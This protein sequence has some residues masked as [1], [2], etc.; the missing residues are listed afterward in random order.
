MEES[1]VEGNTWATMENKGGAFKRLLD[2]LGD[3]ELD[4]DSI[5]EYTVHLF[6]K[7][8]QP[9]SVATDIRK[10]RA[11]INWTS[12][13]ERGITPLHW[14]KLI[15]VPKV[16]NKEIDVPSAEIAEKIIYEGANLDKYNIH[17]AI[18]NEARDCMLLMLR[19]GLRV[20]EALNLK[21]EDL[22]LE[23]EGHEWFRVASKGKHGEKD[24]LPLMASAVEIL[25]RPRVIRVGCYKGQY[26][27][28]SEESLNSML[29]RGCE[30]LGVAK[31]TTHKLR[32]IFGTEMA[33]A[34]IPSYHLQRL[35]RHSELETT[36]RYYIHLQLEDFRRSLEMYHPLA[37]RE[38]TPEQIMNQLREQI[39]QLKIY[40]DRRFLVTGQGNDLSVKVV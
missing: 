8:L 21:R 31:I 33:R 14:P 11:F 5:R 39:K 13:P 3:R 10:Y 37:L 4:P 28:C 36:L 34:G 7:G 18:N 32:H 35:M 16:P 26:F 24:K 19:T 30:K 9:S 29:K 17:R 1:S 25:R 20:K 22:F 27:G 23:T 15:K 2:W 6:N 38:R 40:E 12:A